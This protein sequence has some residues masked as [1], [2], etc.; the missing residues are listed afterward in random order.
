MKMRLLGTVT[1][2]VE[3]ANM[4]VS[5]AY[6]DLIFL[7]HKGFLLQLTD[8]GQEVL[9]HINE[10][11]RESELAEALALLQKKAEERTMVFR[12]GDY[13]RMS[14]AEEDCLHIEFMNTVLSPQEIIP[15]P[16]GVELQLIR[17]SGDKPLGGRSDVSGTRKHFISRAATDGYDVS[18]KEFD[19]VLKAS[20][21][22]FEKT[23]NRGGKR[24]IRWV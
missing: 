20:G 23:G 12:T 13:F 7:E 19:T 11:V 1:E 9:I 21:N 17:G 2:I 22:I 3:S 8:R 16:Q 6:E 24:E 14:L 15:G 4:D 18:V 5:Y 10:E